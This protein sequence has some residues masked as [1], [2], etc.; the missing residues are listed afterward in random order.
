MDG[1][2]IAQMGLQATETAFMAIVSERNVDATLTS[3][4]RELQNEYSL[5]FW[6]W[7]QM[8]KFQD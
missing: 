3:Y 6:P 4:G 8:L 7:V 1:G 5:Q 2:D